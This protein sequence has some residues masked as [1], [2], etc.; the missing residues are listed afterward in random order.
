MKYGRAFLAAALPAILAAGLLAGCGKGTNGPNGGP[1][2]L[3]VYC[4]AG[5]RPPVDEI[6][7][8]FNKENEAEVGPD[9][10]GSEVLLSRLK[11][12]KRGDVY[13][14]GDKHYVDQAATAGF[15]LS[16]KTVCFFVPTILVQKGNPKNIK[17]LRDL[18][19]PGIRLGLG[20]E[21]SCA[22]GRKAK[23]IFKKNGIPWDKVAENLK[24]QS[25]TV[26]E[27]GM[28]IAA[29]SLDAV[30]VWDA[31]AE[32]Y[33]KDGDAVPIPVEQNVVSTV[34]AAVLT[35]TVNRGLAKKFVEFMA[36]ERGRTVFKKHGYRVEPPE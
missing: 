19:K 20:D 1:R 24:F 26:N 6:I 31:M 33:K 23:K 12:L 28:Q 2:K 32:Y 25:A 5:I 18:L 3:L 10:A 36:S 15:V 35:A 4:G 21:R 17:G 8:I 13:M 34:D 30:I 16:R 9:Y 22:I 27:L 29:K 11:L 14:P 7:K